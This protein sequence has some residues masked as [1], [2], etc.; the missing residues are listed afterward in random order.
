VGSPGTVPGSIVGETILPGGMSGVLG[1][2][3]Y[4]NLL[5][6][7]LTNETYPLRTEQSQILRKADSILLLVPAPQP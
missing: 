6:R 3:F 4:A 2:R 1:D 7:F 5:G